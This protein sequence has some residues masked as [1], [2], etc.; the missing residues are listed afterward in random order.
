[1]NL[2]LFIAYIAIIINFVF[3]VNENAPFSM[4][5]AKIMKSCRKAEKFRLND[6]TDSCFIRMIYRGWI[7]V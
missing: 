4:I 5:F 2:F 1:M 6:I 7:Y 3:F